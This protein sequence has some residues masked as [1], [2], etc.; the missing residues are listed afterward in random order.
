[1]FDIAACFVKFVAGNGLSVEDDDDLMLVFELYKDSRRLPL[2]VSVKNGLICTE[3]PSE[4]KGSNVANAGNELPGENVTNVGNELPSENVS[5]VGN[6]INGLGTQGSTPDNVERDMSMN[7]MG[8]GMAINIRE[9]GRSLPLRG[10]GSNVSMRGRGSSVSIR[11]RGNS[12]S[13]RGSGSSVSMRGRGEKTNVLPDGEFENE[14]SLTEIEDNGDYPKEVMFDNAISTK[15]SNED[16][17][18]DDSEDDGLSNYAS[19]N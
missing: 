7:T 8:S 4:D 11:G 2:V 3:L 6:V 13:M 14:I 19:D 17:V 12:V 16:F 18:L 15:E 9:K 1:M 5:K 10:R